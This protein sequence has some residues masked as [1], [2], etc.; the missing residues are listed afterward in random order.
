MS[1]GARRMRAVRLTWLSS[2]H[3]LFLPEGAANKQ[4]VV[5]F[6]VVG[7]EEVRDSPLR[8]RLRHHATI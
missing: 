1:L 6:H 4:L 5:Q 7:G 8:L 2:S 3:G